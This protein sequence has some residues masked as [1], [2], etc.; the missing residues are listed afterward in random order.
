MAIKPTIVLLVGLTLASV[1]LAE[2]QQAKKL[3]RDAR[4]QGHG[5]W[6]GFKAT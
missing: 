2:A 5:S 4:E 1:H 3:P 6:N